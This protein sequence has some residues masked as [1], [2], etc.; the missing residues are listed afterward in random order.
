MRRM[1]TIVTVALAAR[2]SHAAELRSVLNTSAK[3]NSN[4]PGTGNGSDQGGGGS[5]QGQSDVRL[6]AGAGFNV[7][8]DPGRFNWRIGYAPAY[9]RF[10]QLSD[11]DN[12]RHRGWGSF[13]YGLTRAT[14]LG[15]HAEFSRSTRTNLEPLIDDVVPAPEPTLEEIDEQIERG[16]M[17][18]TLSHAFGPR[19]SG[20][21][22]TGYSY[23][24]YG[25]EDRSD[26]E[27]ANASASLSYAMTSRQSLGGGV[28]FSR[29]IVEEAD[30]QAGGQ[31]I[32][33]GAE[34]ETRFASL[35]GSWTY[36][37]S[38]LWRLDTRAG[39]TFIDSDFGG[40]AVEPPPVARVPSEGGFPLDG[41]LC[42]FVLPTLAGL[43]VNRDCELHP[44]PLPPGFQS[45]TAPVGSE[46]LLD[47]GTST[48]LFANF[49][50][51]RSAE[52]SQFSL[53]Y[54]RS[55]GENYGGRTST[56]SDVLS[57]R[58]TWRPDADWRFDFR[59]SYAKQ[60]QATSASVAEGFPLI[61]N[62]GTV[63]G[64]AADV[65]IVDLRPDGSA[66]VRTG[67]VDNAFDVDSWTVQLRATRRLTRRLS[68]FL[69]MGYRDQT[70]NG[71]EGGVVDSLDQFEVGLGLTYAFDP[72]RL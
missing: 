21:T 14:Q 70:N 57:S 10:L 33:T 6:D 29:Q 18:L 35:F 38:P 68:G 58:W 24:D 16:S 30:V 20:N 51:V 54:S 63:P 9:E 46:N 60:Q 67:E 45:P 55:A 8:S 59:A 37:L 69:S 41:N 28:S 23:V 2:A 26:F 61:P 36:Q 15:G 12:W 19:W 64:L 62:A 52:R 5:E 4:A 40:D 32:S 66:R 50:I 25:R 56:V 1:V 13:Q 42:T 17:G 72:L 65:A 48:T 47:Q 27:G 11:L 39:P 43:I 49:G 3:W 53:N 44:A 22:S 71:V 7:F 34:Q 31:D